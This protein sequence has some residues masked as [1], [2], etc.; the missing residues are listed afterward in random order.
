M[1]RSSS[2]RVIR[3]QGAI[4][5]WNFVLGTWNFIWYNTYDMPIKSNTESQ[6][7]KVTVLLWV[8]V[9]GLCTVV[10]NVIAAEMF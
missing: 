4:T 3:G 2:D 7:I 10:A 6:D 9:A 8:I 5:G 1:K